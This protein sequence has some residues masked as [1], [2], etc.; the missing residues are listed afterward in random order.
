MIN[1]S[2]SFGRAVVTTLGVAGAC[3]T[4]CLAYH[5]ILKRTIEQKCVSQLTATRIKVCIVAGMLAT[6]TCVHLFVGVVASQ[7]S[8]VAMTVGLVYLLKKGILLKSFIISQRIEDISRNILTVDRVENSESYKEKIQKSQLVWTDEMIA[9]ISSTPR[10]EPLEKFFEYSSEGGDENNLFIAS[11]ARKA[12][13]EGGIKKLIEDTIFPAFKKDNIKA[14]GLLSSILRLLTIEKSDQILI[15][16]KQKDATIFDFKILAQSVETIYKKNKKDGGIIIGN[17][18]SALNPKQQQEF[19]EQL[20]LR[21]ELRE[22]RETLFDSLSKSIPTDSTRIYIPSLFASEQTTRIIRNLKE[23][24]WLSVPQQHLLNSLM[25]FDFSNVKQL[26]IKGE[27]S[28]DTF[29]GI[30]RLSII[31][32]NTFRISFIPLKEQGQM[33]QMTRLTV[34][35]HQIKRSGSFKE[36]GSNRKKGVRRAVTPEQ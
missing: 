35:T 14:W 3:T 9:K 36:V 20:I 28:E 31:E 23:V 27:I 8:L 4:T 7:I 15:S 33:L 24:L 22:D 16:L 34:L 25:V 21:P 6:G 12:Y 11:I 10:Q 30:R 19:Q 13:E 32:N 5:T 17:I 2:S 18:L 29:E 26:N 1:V